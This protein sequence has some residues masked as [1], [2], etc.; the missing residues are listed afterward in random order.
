MAT[1]QSVFS[2]R[3]G[4]YGYRGPPVL[5]DINLTMEAGRFYGL[6]GPNGSGK[7]TLL[8]LLAATSQPDTGI[9]LFKGRPVR[10]YRRQE[11]ARQLALVPQDFALGFDYTVFDVVLMGRHP[12]IPRF[13]NPTAKDLDLVEEALAL[14]DIKHL[15]DRVVTR[16]S[17]GEKQRT[18]VARAL[19]Q[20][21]Q[22]L[23]LDE[24]TSSLDIKH[25]IEIMRAVS[26][27]VRFKALTVI[28]AIHDLNLAAAFC[29]ELVVLK[30]GR[31]VAKGPV[32]DVL[33]SRLIQEVFS[34]EGHIHIHA[35][36]LGI[37]Y[38]FR[39]NTAS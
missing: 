21:P 30:A 12:H 3:D 24:A 33:T 18:I 8:D 38:A 2:I 19:A 5:A 9:V 1:P 10:S 28:A 16:L 29:D 7:T 14:M 32:E 37:E 6:I 31:I 22:V 34:V 13:S 23:I 4:W 17:G 36:T 11:L 15:R 26:D 35:Q 27:R 25:T 20:D 39:K